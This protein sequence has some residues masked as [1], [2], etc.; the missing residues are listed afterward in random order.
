M[1]YD[2]KIEVLNA[3]NF[4]VIANNQGGGK[5]LGLAHF[6]RETNHATNCW[7]ARVDIKEKYTGNKI[8]TR[9]LQHGDE[10][11]A[12][13][14]P[15]ELRLFNDLNSYSYLVY[16]SLIS[17]NQIIDFNQDGLLFKP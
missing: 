8:A 5:L 12:Q 17:D 3:K 1:N 7:G 16:T 11:I 6:F 10:F 14:Y 9:L 13:N 4:L 15:E 2:S